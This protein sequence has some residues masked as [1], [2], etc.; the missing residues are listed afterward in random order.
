MASPV[1]LDANAIIYALDE[2]SEFYAN[3]V[4]I[5]QGLLREG[6]ELCTSHHVIEEVLHIA[7]KATG[8]KTKPG[9]VVNEIANIP[10]LILIEPAAEL[11]FALRYAKLCES[12]NIGVNDALLLQLILDAGLTQ[13][14]SYDKK[15]AAKATKLGITVIA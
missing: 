7:V 8:G 12:H 3:T 14:F 10:G 5:F 15:F 1:F 9:A 11:D 6:S 2:T 13:L 4:G